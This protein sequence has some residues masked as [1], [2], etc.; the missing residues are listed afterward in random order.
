MIQ[1]PTT[2]ATFTHYGCHLRTPR[3]PPATARRPPSNGAASP[4]EF[5]GAGTVTSRNPLQITLSPPGCHPP[6]RV[7]HPQ[8]GRLHHNNTP[9]AYC[10]ST[11][12]TKHRGELRNRRGGEVNIVRAKPEPGGGPEQREKE[13]P[14]NDPDKEWYQGRN[15]SSRSDA[16]RSAP[17]SPPS[18]AG[19]PP[20]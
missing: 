14:E 20:L 4:Q 7:G 5:V 17:V 1:G 8:S 15:L 2:A 3:V 16:F 6:R 13:S 18:H 10:L 11:P 9:Q 12:A 19:T